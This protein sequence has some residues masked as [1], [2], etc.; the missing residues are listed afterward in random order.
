METI[1]IVGY[2]YNTGTSITGEDNHFNEC[3]NDFLRMISFFFWFS[4]WLSWVGWCNVKHVVTWRW[5]C[6]WVGAILLAFRV[7][8]GVGV[9]NS[10]AT[11]CYV[12]PLIILQASL[13]YRT[14]YVSIS[15]ISNPH[16]NLEV[17]CYWMIDRWMETTRW[18]VYHLYSKLKYI[19]EC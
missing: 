11:C 3:G 5:I 10:S 17:Y 13:P 14:W 6:I 4:L 12:L 1:E 19:N 7:F 16:N 15:L 2:K 9:P 18:S 8:L